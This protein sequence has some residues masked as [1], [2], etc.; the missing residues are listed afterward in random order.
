MSKELLKLLIESRLENESK[1]LY[2]EYLQILL[3][4]RDTSIRR[5]K[6]TNLSLKRTNIEL[7]IDDLQGNHVYM[8][9][10]VYVKKRK[11]TVEL[12]KELL[13]YENL[14]KLVPKLDYTPKHERLDNK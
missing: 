10:G 7:I 11:L 13:N 1:A 9:E 14:D 8:L 6:L 3:D 5:K 4:E 2:I 12:Y